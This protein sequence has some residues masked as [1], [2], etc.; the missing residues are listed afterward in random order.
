MLCCQQKGG[1]E[2][3]YCAYCSI[4][5]CCAYCCS[6]YVRSPPAAQETKTDNAQS[7]PVFQLYC[8]VST[9]VLRF[10]FLSNRHKIY[11]A[12]CPCPL[13]LRTSYSYTTIYHKYELV[14]VCL[15]TTYNGFCVLV[16]TTYSLATGS[17][18]RR[19]G[20]YYSSTLLPCAV[21][22]ENKQCRPKNGRVQEVCLGSRQRPS[23]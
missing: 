19:C 2:G 6:T 11:F 18:R 23:S 5:C 9:T 4:Y 13:P 20:L 7:T 22:V 16:H 14:Y 12:R 21:G 8:S 15:C 3:I 10:H 17:K 1:R